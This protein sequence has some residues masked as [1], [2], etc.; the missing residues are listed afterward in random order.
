MRIWLGVLLI[1]T[2][3]CGNDDASGGEAGRGGEGGDA[4]R[5]DAGRG[6]GGGGAGRAGSGG[7]AGGGGRAAGSGGSDS[8][9]LA[10]PQVYPLVR[11]NTPTG[12]IR[13]PRFQMVSA[14]S[15]RNVR[16]LPQA[17][18]A[19]INLAVAV[20]ERLY[21][22]G[23]TAIL[24]IVKDL[25]DRVAGLDTDVSRH[26]C[27]TSDPVSVTY[28]LP[29]GQTFTVKLQCFQ[30]FGTPGAGAGWLA[31][32]F[33]KAPFVR[34]D[35]GDAGTESDAGVEPADG[36]DH[37]YLIEGQ[38]GG[39]GGAYHIDRANG[40]VEAWIAVA[41]KTIPM[42]SQVIMHLLSRKP[43][44]TLE[45][46]FAGSAVGFCSAHLKTS[47]DHIFVQGRTNGA[48]APGAIIA[49]GTQVCDAARAGCFAIA[50]LEVDLGPDANG[51][52][53]IAAS[54]FD[55]ATE[56]DASSDSGANVSFANIYTYF[57]EPPTGIP[58]F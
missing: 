41:E 47:A 28:A 26:A 5:S 40:N 30:S 7:A 33:D 53:A 39:M 54:T 13:D 21:S 14:A 2:I 6:G 1:A 43:E 23:P 8:T 42:N 29:G 58:A 37:F 56:L 50:A 27:L 17:L 55:I 9:R 25:D 31:F 24:R 15:S 19:S 49:P 34:G 45:L 51:C 3:G 36:G 22:M 52:S 18:T 57:D 44:K 46:A 12:L 48:A 4:G 32:G 38:P 16:S 11:A 20:Q 10:L 35:A